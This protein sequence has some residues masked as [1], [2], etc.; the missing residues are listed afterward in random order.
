[1][2]PKNPNKLIAALWEHKRD[3]WFLNSGGKE[4]LIQLLM[5]EKIGTKKLQKHLPDGDLGR[6]GLAISRNKPN[7]VY[8]LIELKTLYLTN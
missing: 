5:A 1:M 7:I 3:P 4:V 6:I 2:D 8:A